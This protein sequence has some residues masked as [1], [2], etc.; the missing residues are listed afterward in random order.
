MEDQALGACVLRRHIIEARD[1]EA[2][3]ARLVG[4]GQREG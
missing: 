1:S 3:R 4:W 2:A